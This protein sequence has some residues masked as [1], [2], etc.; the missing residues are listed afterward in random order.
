MIA[1]SD[2]LPDPLR[3]ALEARYWAPIGDAARIEAVIDDPA[4][5]AD[6]ARHPALFS[7]HGVV[8]VR[9]IAIGAV[10]LAER[11]PGLLLPRRELG[12]RR[13]VQ[14]LAV[15]LT[16]FHDIGMAEATAAARRVHPQF[17]AQTVLGADFDS[18]AHALWQ[19]DAGG[20]RSRVQALGRDARLPLP[21]P[22]VAR[23]VLAMSL[24]HSKTAVPAEW[25]DDPA[26]L[27][28]VMTRACLTDLV[29]Q[30]TTPLATH[31][32][33]GPDTRAPSALVSRYADAAAQAFAWLTD[34]QPAVRAFVEEVMD[35]VRLLRAADALRQRGTTLRTSAGYEVCTDRRSGHA[36]VGL[37]TLDER[38]ALLLQVDNPMTAAEANIRSTSITAKGA[39]A[40]EF[41]RGAFP[42]PGARERL[43]TV[44]ADMVAD[45]E[46]DA[47]GSFVDARGR[48]AVEI[49]S[50]EDDPGFAQALARTLTQR[51]PALAPRVQVQPPLPHAAQQD[52]LLAW[53]QR[54]GR[55]PGL[56]AA[57]LMDRLG[58]QGLQVDAIDAGR[59]LRGVRQL[60][61]P[62]GR[63]LMSP[64]LAA[65]AVIVP[66]GPG[67]ELEPAGGY[68]A[69]PL[70]PWLP[71]GATGVVRGGER[72]AAVSAAEAVD[73]LV[74]DGPHYLAEWF[75]PYDLP[76]LRGW[77]ASRSAG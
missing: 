29:A 45:I 8:H 64:G 39:L 65:G 76:T 41:Y 18:L 47:L 1:L 50:P 44:M 20:L 37:R 56:S 11:L 17:A 58:R 36:V 14:G 32:D 16:Y 3:L 6:P 52:E 69:Q 4:L 34:D 66:M 63:R 60:R 26:R 42:S 49:R 2:C 12:P 9:D 38:C 68:A 5:H 77:L 13:F 74:I 53:S 30:Q 19:A 7:D 23:E 25:L 71:I 43:L 31:A 70:H 24:C 72:N 27:R 48:A 51:F 10:D 46:A 21:E 59:A 62:P 55:L 73:V 35:A 33:F 22:W 40:I 28:K 54:D 15:L 57:D 61:V 67:L 75:R